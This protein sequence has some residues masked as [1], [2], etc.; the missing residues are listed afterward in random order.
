M[1]HLPFFFLRWIS[2]IL[3]RKMCNKMQHMIQQHFR[4]LHIYMFINIFYDI[5][6][7]YCYYYYYCYQSLLPHQ[8]THDPCGP[9]AFFFPLL[10]TTSHMGK[11]CKIV[12]IVVVLDMLYLGTIYLSFCYK[13]DKVYLYFEKVKKVFL[14]IV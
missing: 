11:L 6:F 14:K 9:F 4:L 1:V 3:K 13:F 2:I 8:F 10:L 5:S 7:S 12:K